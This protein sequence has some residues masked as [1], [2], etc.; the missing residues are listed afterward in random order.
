MGTVYGI[1]VS[2]AEKPVVYFRAAD[3][4]ILGRVLC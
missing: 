4:S 1:C 3:S 2:F